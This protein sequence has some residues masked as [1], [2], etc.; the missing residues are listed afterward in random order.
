MLLKFTFAASL[1]VFATGCSSF[2]PTYPTTHG[3]QP[4]RVTGDLIDLTDV[5]I[6]INGEK[7]IDDQVTLLAGAGEF[8]GSYAGKPV[9]ADCSTA[10][11]RKTPGTKCAVFL[12]RQRVATLTF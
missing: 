3:G 5:K 7:V 12:E 2:S 10:A 6:F 9:T 1:A 4:L 8:H 11:G